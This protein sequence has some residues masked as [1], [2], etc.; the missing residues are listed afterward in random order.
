MKKL[1]PLISVMLPLLGCASLNSSTPAYGPSNPAPVPAAKVRTYCSMVELRPEKEAEYR[2]LH[3]DVWPE[4]KAAIHRA[5]IR[6][7][8]IYVATV[9][10]RRYLVSHF[11]YIGTNPSKDFA[12]IAQDS[13]TRDK[14]WPVT[15]ACQRVIEGTP[16]GEQWLPME[17]VMHLP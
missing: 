4:V 12:S 1:L 15:D 3:A 6:K 2:Q 13:T 17:Q 16:K 10:G 5:N 9:Q 8:N 14:W 7:F 11:E